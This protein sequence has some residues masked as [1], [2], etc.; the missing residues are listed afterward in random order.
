MSSNSDAKSDVSA[1]DIL[2]II[3]AND[4]AHVNGGSAQVALSSAVG[5]AERGH[6]VTFLAAVPPVA[7]SAHGPVRH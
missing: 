5:L 1:L 4:F 7:E 2:D 3:V 6:R